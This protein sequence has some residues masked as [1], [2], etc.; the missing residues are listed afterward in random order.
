[1][2]N[3][4]R[5]EVIVRFVDIGGTVDNNCLNFLFI[6]RWFN[7]WGFHATS[8]GREESSYDHGKR[9]KF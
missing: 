6:I 7:M 4:L 5:R 3:K 2:L 1:M 8:H 9:G